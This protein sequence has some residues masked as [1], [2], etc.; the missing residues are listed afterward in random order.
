MGAMQV[1]LQ[2]IN[3]LEQVYSTLHQNKFQVQL[4]DI[5]RITFMISN[6]FLDW[7]SFVHSSVQLWEDFYIQWI[8]NGKDTLVIYYD[9]LSSDLLENTL[10]NIT[11]FL[12]LQ[13]ND[14]RVRCTFKHSNNKRQKHNTC[15]PKGH[16]DI[17]SK[18]FMSHSTNCGSTS[19]VN[20]EF[21]IYTKRHMIWINSAIENVQ[22]EI[23][24]RGL[25]SSLMPNYKNTNV[26]LSICTDN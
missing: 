1:T 16:L 8:R 15:F 19:S 22:R 10:K 23:E 7:D 11:R 6:V 12:H 2:L 18:E 14:H 4:N 26:S 5:L 20:C 25:D 3:F 21:N 13:W 9:S 17:N 24:K